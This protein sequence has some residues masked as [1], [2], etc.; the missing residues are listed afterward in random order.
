MLLCTNCIVQIVP[1]RFSLMTLHK[2]GHA[3]QRS[4][5]QVLRHIQSRSSRRKRHYRAY[6]FV[7]GEVFSHT[8]P[9]IIQAL[10]L[11]HTTVPPTGIRT[12]PLGADLLLTMGDQLLDGLDTGLSHR[13]RE[14]RPK[15]VPLPEVR[16]VFFAR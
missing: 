6:E 15:P 2:S 8:T 12:L 5:A 7:T 9:Q 1:T 16:A 3:C 11:I 14:R 10:H 13:V 4:L